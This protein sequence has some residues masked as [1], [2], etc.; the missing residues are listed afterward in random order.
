M[1]GS[2]DAAD[3]EQAI[4]IDGVRASKA[5]HAYHEAWA[6]RSALE[7][8]L[9]TTDLVAITLEGFDARDEA[10]LAAGAVEIADLVRYRG[11]NDVA[12]A[13]WVEVVQFKYSIASAAT[14]YVRP[15]SRGRSPSLR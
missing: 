6:A 4:V 12:R 2:G 11:A 9:P 14:Q 7:L 10:G 1:S 8:L 13:S 3:P 5:G 15:T